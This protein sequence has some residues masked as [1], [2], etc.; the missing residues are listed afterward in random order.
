MFSATAGAE[1]ALGA[2]L[3]GRGVGDGY[4]ADAPSGPKDTEVVSKWLQR[5]PRAPGAPLTLNF[6][7]TVNLHETQ[8]L[9]LV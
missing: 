7:K 1:G 6:S 5:E 4:G 3:T 9:T 8:L 2:G